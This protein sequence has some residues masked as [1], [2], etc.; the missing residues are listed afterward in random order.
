MPR[1]KILHTEVNEITADEL[2][3]ELK[4]LIKENYIAKLYRQGQQ[5][6]IT[7]LNGQKFLL[8][9]KEIRYET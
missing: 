9:L 5:L 3:G 4:L 2:M 7:F 8:T 6:N 1:K